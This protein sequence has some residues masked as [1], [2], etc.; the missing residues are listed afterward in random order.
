MTTN[1]VFDQAALKAL[2]NSADLRQFVSD[3]GD[4]VAQRVNEK[5]AKVLTPGEGGGVGS[6]ESTIATDDQGFYARGSYPPDNFYMW[7]HQFGTEREKPRPTVIPALF[8][9]RSSGGKGT[10]AIGRIRQDKKTKLRTK[11]NRSLAKTRSTS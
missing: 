10:S 2:A 9:T 5:D 6:F 4:A 11:R 1:L 8:A 7:F 3:V